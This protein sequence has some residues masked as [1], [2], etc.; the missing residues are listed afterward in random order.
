[1]LCYR[2][3]LSQHW[4]HHNTAKLRPNSYILF[5][6]LVEILRFTTQPFI[7][8]IPIKMVRET[9]RISPVVAIVKQLRNGALDLKIFLSLVLHNLAKVLEKLTQNILCKR[10]C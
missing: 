10:H 9:S 1:M 2:S 7:P 3:F 4:V 5:Y 8:F 6:I